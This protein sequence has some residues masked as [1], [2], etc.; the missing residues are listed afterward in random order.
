M[1]S[2]EPN[3]HKSS[4]SSGNADNCIEVADNG[5]VAVLVRDTKQNGRGAVLAVG[6]STWSAFVNFAKESAV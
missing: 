6:P 1:N 2:H 4:Y 5:P 3:W